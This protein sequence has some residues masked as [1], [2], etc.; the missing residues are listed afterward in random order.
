[1]PTTQY[2]YRDDVSEAATE[3]D[4]QANWADDP[5]DLA[6][7]EFDIEDEIH[8]EYPARHDGLQMLTTF[9]ITTRIGVL[10]GQS[11]ASLWPSC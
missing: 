3:Y 5:T 4:D 6:L 1:M 7:Q 2:G 10:Y 11:S 9:L 8:S